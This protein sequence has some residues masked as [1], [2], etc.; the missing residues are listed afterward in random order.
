M[1]LYEDRVSID[2]QDRICMHDKIAFHPCDKRSVLSVG[3]SL[4]PKSDLNSMGIKP[5][6]LFTELGGLVVESLVFYIDINTPRP[7]YFRGKM[8]D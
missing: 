4:F 5:C 1:I 6:V 7:T 2:H 3:C 8:I